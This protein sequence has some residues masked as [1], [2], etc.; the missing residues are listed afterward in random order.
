M[1]ERQLLRDECLNALSNY[2]RQAQKTCELLGDIEG[3]SFSLDRLLAIL[4]HTQAEQ[5][6][7]KSYLALRQRLFDGLIRT[8]LSDNETSGAGG[9]PAITKRRGKARYSRQAR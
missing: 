5:E 9:S 8:E 1:T 7:Q 2:V 3:N 6:V 4:A